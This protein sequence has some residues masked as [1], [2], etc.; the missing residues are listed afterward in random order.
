LQAL[1]LRDADRTGDTLPPQTLIEGRHLWS[2]Q[3]KAG[4]G[5]ELAVHEGGGLPHSSAADAMSS[6]FLNAPDAPNTSYMQT[7]MTDLN[8]ALKQSHMANKRAIDAHQDVPG[9]RRPFPDAKS[10][11]VVD[12]TPKASIFLPRKD[13]HISI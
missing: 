13:R 11:T 1:A 8:L 9:L 10:R 4:I 3:E 7:T 12:S 6:A 2:T 5:P